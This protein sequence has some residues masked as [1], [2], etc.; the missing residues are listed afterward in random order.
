MCSTRLFCCFQ[1]CVRAVDDDTFQRMVERQYELLRKERNKDCSDDDKS[2]TVQ[3]AAQQQQPSQAEPVV[4]ASEDSQPATE[5]LF[6]V[7]TV[8]KMSLC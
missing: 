8:L 5:V 1:H 2:S 6:C 4:T 3:E 7:S